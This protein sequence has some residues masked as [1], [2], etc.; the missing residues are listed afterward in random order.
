MEVVFDIS[1][2]FSAS[3]IRGLKLDT[4]SILKRLTGPEDS[5]AYSCRASL[6]SY[7]YLKV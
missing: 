5:I 4:N 7:K 1:E 6:E 2:T 3:A